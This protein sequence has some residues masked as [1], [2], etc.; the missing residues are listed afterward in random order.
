MNTITRF[1]TRSL[2]LLTLLCAGARFAPRCS[3]APGALDPTFGGTGKVTTNFG[4]GDAQCQSVAVQSDGKIVVAG[5]AFN[6]GAIGGGDFAVVR[7]NLD[8][9]LDTSFNG[10][11]KVTTDFA[12]GYDYGQSVAIQSDGKIVVAG[13]SITSPMVTSGWC[14]T[15][16][17]EVSIRT[18]VALAKW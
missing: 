11:G 1:L 13:L 2:L 8:G 15:I 5:I 3:A 18:L 17:T 16:L 9:S 4:S 10:T 6:A 14:V 12:G 7:Y